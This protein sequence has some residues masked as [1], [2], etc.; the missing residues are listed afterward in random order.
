MAYP[1]DVP[2]LETEAL[3]ALGRLDGALGAARPR[4]LRLLAGQQLRTLLITAL[5]QEG[6]SF[7]DQRFHAWCAGL[8]TLSDAPPRHLRAPRAVCEAILTEL[9]HS[10]WEPLAALAAKFSAALL[11]PQ[12][13]E[14][15]V[16]D[17]E[18]GHAAAHSL[19]TGARN[20]IEALE[21]SPLPLPALAQ[22]HRAVAAHI[23][24]A[25]PERALVPISL[26]AM[27][28]TVERAALPSPRWALEMLWGEHWRAAGLLAHA[29]PF[30]G[31]IRLDASPDAA[32][33]GEA[34]IIVAGA[35]REVAQSLGGSLV[36]AGQ[37]S[38]RIDDLQPGR[39]RTSRAPAL[40]E[41]LAGFGPLRSAQIETLLGATRLGVRTMLAALGDIGVLERTT[42][43]GVCLYSVNL[44]AHPA[45]DVSE[46]AAGFA[47]SSAALG[48]YDAAM[49]GIEALLNRSGVP[50]ADAEED[51]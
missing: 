45:P 35:L 44:S 3:L 9:A 47:F 29:L 36:K 43:A 8:A 18:T 17:A 11:A 15:S 25:P 48:E 49:A 19:V 31:L 39:R 22:L 32:G 24:F 4:T 23:R 51:D 1:G 27:R 37:L 38:R 20:L 10:S 28:L 5:R 42:L 34:R 41:L 40:L 12:D 26:G 21:P 50:L 13:H 7:T 33:P 6:H 16:P 14:D 2:T 46:P 30:P